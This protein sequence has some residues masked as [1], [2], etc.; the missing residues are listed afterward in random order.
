MSKSILTSSIARA[1]GRGVHPDDIRESLEI[2]IGG[3]GTDWD[4]ATE[5]DLQGT[6]GII[7][8]LTARP[9]GIDEWWDTVALDVIHDEAEVV[10]L[11][12]DRVPGG[13]HGLDDVRV[14]H[15]IEDMEVLV[16]HDPDCP[17]K[18]PCLSKDVFPQLRVTIQKHGFE[19]DCRLIN[20]VCRADG[21]LVTIHWGG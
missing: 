2:G 13:P 5:N 21:I 14:P 9:L 7:D 8:R 11:D 6:A 18:I 10:V 3:D 19:F 4:S 20:M 12:T 15:A 1:Q 16:P 17:F